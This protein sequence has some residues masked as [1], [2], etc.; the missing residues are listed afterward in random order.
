VRRAADN[1]D[2]F[3]FDYGVEWRGS[4]NLS[5]NKLR[6]KAQDEVDRTGIAVCNYKCLICKNARCDNAGSLRSIHNEEI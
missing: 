1:N 4:N 6:R 2:I 3:G 5:Q